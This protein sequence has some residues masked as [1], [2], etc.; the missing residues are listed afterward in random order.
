[1]F[2][3][4][5]AL[6]CE[7]KVN[8]GVLPK[9]CPTHLPHSSVEKVN[10]PASNLYPDGVDYKFRQLLICLEQ[11]IVAPGSPTSASIKASR[12][13]THN[14]MAFVSGSSSLSEGAG[15]SEVMTGENG[16]SEVGER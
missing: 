11:G 2:Q 9:E 5:L 4:V 12:K 13:I 16:V 10:D 3:S 14:D 15:R 6:L 8:G 7:A 1:M